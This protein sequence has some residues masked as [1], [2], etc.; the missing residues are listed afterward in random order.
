MDPLIW[1]ALRGVVSRQTLNNM[2]DVSTDDGPYKWHCEMVMAILENSPIKVLQI[3]GDH[4]FSGNDNTVA[5]II[6]NI[7]VSKLV[8]SGY[9]NPKVKEPEQHSE[10]RQMDRLP[11]HIYKALQT[12]YDENN[13]RLKAGE[14]SQLAKKYGIEA[15]RI[16]EYY[17]VRHKNQKSRSAREEKL[18][19]LSFDVSKGLC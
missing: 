6:V 2:I 15:R 11:R 19:Q 10:K 13:G 18:S 16:S 8:N 17:R 3:A 4:E 9:L 1:G 7:A 12:H 5:E 14:A